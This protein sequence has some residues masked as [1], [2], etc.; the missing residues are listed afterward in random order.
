MFLKC[1][2]HGYNENK[3]I[4]FLIKKKNKISKLNSVNNLNIVQ[5]H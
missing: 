1:S 2:G 4:F 3:L 5:V